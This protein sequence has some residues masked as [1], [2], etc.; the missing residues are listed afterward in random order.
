MQIRFQRSTRLFLVAIV[1]LLLANATHP[2]ATY[3]VT[4]SRATA[5]V[6][7]EVAASAVAAGLVGGAVGAGAGA[8]VCCP[9]GAV[10]A[11][12]VGVVAA[13]L[14]WYF[15]GRTSPTPPSYPVSAID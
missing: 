15:L 14:S 6:Q 3:A 13:G 1:G 5:P 11:G 12:V 4:S 9:V 8:M 2:V 10:V 7:Q